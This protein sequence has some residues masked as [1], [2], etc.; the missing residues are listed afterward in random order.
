MRGCLPRWIL[1]FFHRLAFA[2]NFFFLGLFGVAGGC[3]KAF[4]QSRKVSFL[5]QF[6][7]GHSA[8]KWIAFSSASRQSRQSVSHSGGFQCRKWCLKGPCPV[9]SCMTLATVWWLQSLQMLSRFKCFN[10]TF[11]PQ[12]FVILVPFKVPLTNHP[13]YVRPFQ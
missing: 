6:R 12:G 7:A 5:A 8:I 11:G 9:I 4:V 3:F 1:K 2:R 10:K 13:V